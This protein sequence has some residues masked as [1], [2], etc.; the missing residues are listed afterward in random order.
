[1]RKKAKPRKAISLDIQTELLADFDEM[2]YVRDISRSR[3][4]RDLMTDAVTQYR[5]GSEHN[6]NFDN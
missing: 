4:I 2:C 5:K 6:E 1:M 3:A